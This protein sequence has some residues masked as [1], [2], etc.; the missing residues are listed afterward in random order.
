MKDYEQKYPRKWEEISMN[1]M[2]LRVPRGW[3]VSVRADE[4]SDPQITFLSDPL[5][6][7][8]LEDPK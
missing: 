3:L 4:S 2:R 7:W 1:T 6:D 5:G 8:E